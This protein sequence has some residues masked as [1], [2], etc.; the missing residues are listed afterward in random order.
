MAQWLFKNGPISVGKQM[1]LQL[2]K[3]EQLDIQIYKV[4]ARVEGGLEIS[5]NET[6]MAQWLFKNGP[7]SV[8]KQI[9]LQL[10]Q[11]KCQIDRYIRLQLEWKEVW[12][13]LRMKLR[14]LSGS[15]R[16]VLSLLVSKYFFS[17][18]SENVRQIDIYIRSFQKMVFSK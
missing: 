7:I 2:V 8:G 12:R 15:S 16:M 9:F 14:W 17:Q 11:L 4:V 3:L 10:A 1:F 5:Q 13:Y 6:Q 18:F